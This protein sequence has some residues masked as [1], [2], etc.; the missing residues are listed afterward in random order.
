M[1]A[2]VDA[3]ERQTALDPTLSFCVSAPAGSGKTEL[4]I[5]RYLRLLAR[6][7]RPEQVLAITFTRKAAAEMRGRVLQALQEASEALPCDS[8]H[9]RV[10][11]DL[12]LQALEADQ[13][14]GWELSRDIARLNIK[15]IDSFCSGLARQMPIL[16]QLGGQ[17][18]AQDDADILYREA[19]AELFGLIETEH[20]LAKDL[21]VL[22]LHFD[23]NWGRLQDLLVSM[24]AR[25]DQWRSYVGVHNQPE[26][27]QTYLQNAVQSLVC[28]ALQELGDALAP[29]QS[30]LLDLQQYAARTLQESQPDTFPGGDPECLPAWRELAKM[31]QTQKGLWRKSITKKQGFPTGKGEPAERKQRLLTLLAEMSEIEGLQEILAAVNALPETATDSDSW[32]LVLHLS[33]LLPMLAAQLLLVFQKHGVVDHSQV[34][35]AALLALGDDDAP[36]DLALRLDYCIEHILIDEFQDTSINQFDLLDKLTRGWGEHNAA[37]PESPRTLMIVGDGMQSIYGFRGANVGLL[38]KAQLEGFNGV[39]LTSLNLRSNFRSDAG[40]VEWV[41]ETFQQAFPANSDASRAEVS[42]SPA[43]AVRPLGLPEAVQTEI[44]TG[45]DARGQEVAFVCDEIAAYHAQEEGTIAVLGRSRNQLQDIITGLKALGVPHNAQDLDSLQDSP[46]VA[47]LMV[48]CRVLTNDSDR[49]AWMALLRAPWCGLCL[50]DLLA[51]AKSSEDARY[52]S[53]WS[54]ID[55]GHWQAALSDDGEQRFRRVVQP[56]Q[57]ARNARD[58][59]GLRVWIEQLWLGLCGPQCAPDA[60]GLQDAESFLQLLEE[61]ESQGMGLDVDWLT[62]KLQKRFMSAS[63]PDSRV[64]LMTLH[65]AKGLEFDR[66]IIPQLARSTGSDKRQ[67][68]L[69]DEHSNAQGQRT[70]LLAADDHSP[71]ESPTLYNYLRE[72]RKYKSRLETTRLLYVGATR[73]IGHLLLTASLGWNDKADTVA[74]PSAGSLLSPIW[75]TVEQQMHVTHT[76]PHT[77]SPA[78][79]RRGKSLRRLRLVPGQ[80][81]AAPISDPAPPADSNIPQYLDNHLD[82]TIGTV[83]HLALEQLSLTKELPGAASDAQ[84]S[85]WRHALM[86]HGVFGAPLEQ[87]ISRVM[88]AVTQTLSDNGAGRW[89]LSNEHTDARS[90]WPLTTVDE[91]GRIR[92]IVIDRSFVDTETGIRWIV[93]YKN[94]QPAQGESLA[95]FTQREAEHYHQQL[96]GY[97][98]ALRFMVDTPL[99]CALFFTALGHLH[100][101]EELSLPREF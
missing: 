54:F 32:L 5:Q 64:H 48:L 9:Q 2:I 12:A 97:R 26:E 78:S 72:R 95:A 99:R 83:V 87:A 1:T 11:R 90:E 13:Q 47:D 65:K 22:M 61:A 53:L 59:L 60:V 20:P 50:A 28:D 19:V 92:D 39:A 17:P 57:R 62:L 71:K 33:R 31:L 15:T 4:L 88:E 76:E 56:L 75:P 8:D 23:N 16:S 18:S 69:W 21:S 46:V 38:L 94:S 55:S 85:R 30:E 3:Q 73:A 36:T 66:V 49:L 80:P 41:N 84:Q 93:D 42:Y 86:S 68:L 91:E 98:D 29:H 24:L 7:E 77:D 34:A 67:L 79:A 14:A 81:E 6:V 89:V 96:L 100:T 37:Q 101:V 45:D 82:R 70:F 25:R 10:T 74:A 27:S 58:R 44:F 43:S 35:E 52:Q 63:D 51:V 40:I